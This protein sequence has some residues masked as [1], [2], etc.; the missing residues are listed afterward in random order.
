MASFVQAQSAVIG[1]D[2]SSPA[3]VSV[4]TV[5]ATKKSVITG[6][7]ATN[8][9]GFNLPIQVCVDKGST[10][11]WIAKD[12]HIDSGSVSHIEGADKMVLASGDVVKADAHRITTNGDAF[13][14]VVSVYED[15]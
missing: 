11:L 15:V 3:P 13:T 4:Y 9:T 7:A 8:K 1:S 12:T 6:I 5:P 10:D 14:I 2:P